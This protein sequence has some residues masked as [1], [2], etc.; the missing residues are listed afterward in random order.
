MLR[1]E[2]P[3]LY[4]DLSAADGL[5]AGDT[6]TLMRVVSAKDAATGRTL[7]DRFRVGTGKVVEAGDAL[8]RVRTTAALAERLAVG[9]VV[10]S[11][12]R[13]PPAPVAAVVAAT[14][15][16]HTI[17]PILLKAANNLAELDATLDLVVASPDLETRRAAWQGFLAL[18]PD[19]PSAD[20]AAAE[21]AA[22]DQRLSARDDEARAVV[23][24]AA[25]QE[26]HPPT[27]SAPMRSPAGEPIQIVV[28]ADPEGG[29][30][31]DG[32]LFYRVG[33][34]E[35]GPFS[36]IPLQVRGSRA[37][38][39]EVPAA[40]AVGGRVDWYVALESEGEADV[41]LGGSATAPSRVDIVGPPP[42]LP[43]EDR[44]QVTLSYDLVDFYKL[45]GVDR[46]G[47]FDAGFLYRVDMGVLYAV[48]VGAGVLDG[49]GADTQALDAAESE[50]ARRELSQDVGYKSGRVEAEL[51]LAPWVSTILRGVV[52]VEL[53]GLH[54]GAAGHVRLGRDEGTH[55]RVGITSVGSVGQVYLLELGW[56]TVPR[57]PM[58]AAVEVTNQP[59]VSAEDYGV[60]MLQEV[61]Y[62]VSDSVEIG[63]RIGYALRN[64]DHGGPTFGGVVVFGW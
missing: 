7:T 32:V 10:T 43:V 2:G 1:V 56:D 35:S 36:A 50:S 21:I 19:H 47:Q 12:D 31:G 14:E 11:V 18:H 52:G 62:E 64:I 51:R 48:G 25:Q 57:F 40:A 42:A 28:V 26:A 58:R 20:A 23:R 6:I 15:A 5:R 55:L 17:D 8:S 54:L 30:V 24:R 27:A 46:Y 53:G 33:Q 63:G 13:A 41:T 38:Y 49:V 39:A 9:D 45:E 44:S 60:R 59:G 29:P 22:L 37:R 34:T 3:D 4:V 16:G 61:R